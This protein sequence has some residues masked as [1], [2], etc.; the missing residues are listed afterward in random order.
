MGL[1]KDLISLS[2][3][4]AFF[5]DDKLSYL[6]FDKSNHTTKVINLRKGTGL[7]KGRNKN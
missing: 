5:L 1:Q 3:L 6:K 7:A 4:L 2:T